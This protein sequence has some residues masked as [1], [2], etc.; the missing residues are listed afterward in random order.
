M[1]TYDRVVSNA[2]P[3]VPVGQLFGAL[4]INERQVQFAVLLYLLLQVSLKMQV[5][6]LR[7][8]IH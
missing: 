5:V 8:P 2:D 7:T 1:A 6:C 3:P 4:W